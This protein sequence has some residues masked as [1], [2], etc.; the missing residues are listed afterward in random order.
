MWC[1]KPV[2]RRRQRS[3]ALEMSVVNDL[4][5]RHPGSRKD[6]LFSDPARHGK[7]TD[8]PRDAARR[9]LQTATNAKV[10][11]ETPILC[12]PARMSGSGLSL[13]FADGAN[14]ARMRIDRD[15]R[16]VRTTC[17]AECWFCPGFVDT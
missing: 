5:R 17:S 13:P 12:R 3:L 2:A 10:E 9:M 7:L 8:P 4:E 1:R 6:R 16:Y 14:H 15:I 11:I